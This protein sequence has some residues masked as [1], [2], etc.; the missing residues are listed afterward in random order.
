MEQKSNVQYR[1]EKE[2]KNSREKFFLL[3]REIISNAIHAVLI[4]KTKE[5]DY[6]PKLNLNITFDDSH[7]TSS[8]TKYVFYNWLINNILYLCV[9]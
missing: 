3:L 7:L 8:L 6:I 1:A 2:Y 4:R 9:T 5:E